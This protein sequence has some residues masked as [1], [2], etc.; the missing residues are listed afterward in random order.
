M[1]LASRTRDTP[2]LPGTGAAGDLT[3]DGKLRWV[4][5]SGGT[6]PVTRVVSY[7][8]YQGDRRSLFRNVVFAAS[9]STSPSAAPSVSARALSG[10]TFSA[11]PTG[12]SV[13]I[14]V[15]FTGQVNS[16]PYLNLF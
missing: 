15:V 4:T 12:Q 11:R 8:R 1:A 14:S 2:A 10:I 16:E 13:T 9:P 3:G 5:C 7:P 6:S